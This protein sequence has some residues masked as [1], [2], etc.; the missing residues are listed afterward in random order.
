MQSGFFSCNSD[1]RIDYPFDNENYMALWA[2]HDCD[3]WDLFLTILFDQYSFR[4]L[5]T[6]TG[7]DLSDRKGC[8]QIDESREIAACEFY[9]PNRDDKFGILFAYN[10][11]LQ[12]EIEWDYN[13]SWNSF[14]GGW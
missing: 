6:S 2:T 8:Y 4:S 11:E 10:H 13:P 12:Y 1:V 14:F 5:V 3:H 9:M 7:A